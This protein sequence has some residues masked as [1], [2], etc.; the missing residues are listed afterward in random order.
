VRPRLVLTTLAAAVT[1]VLGGSALLAGPADA[2]LAI[3][4]VPS[5]TSLSVSTTSVTLGDESAALLSVSVS[6][7]LGFTPTGSVTIKS[8][9]PNGNRFLC[10]TSLTAGKGSCR[11]SDTALFPGTLQLFAVYSGD[12][13]HAAS[14]SGLVPLTVNPAVTEP[15]L[16]QSNFNL[17]FG[18]EQADTLTVTVGP[19]LSG[20]LPPSGAFN[21]TAFV[22]GVSTQI[23]SGTLSQGTGTCTLT[24]S[25]VPVG[26]FAIVAHYAGDDI[27]SRGDS[28]A[29]SIR[30]SQGQST[31][32]LALPSAKLAFDEQNG[33]MLSYSV[34]PAASVPPSGSVSVSATSAASG[35]TTPLC[36]GAL[37]NGAGSCAMTAAQLAPGHYLVTA[38]YGG[39]TNYTGSTST[40]QPFTITRVPT[41]T[42]L[43]RSPAKVR[44]GHEQL[45]HLSVQVTA[46]NGGTPGGNVTIK[47]GTVRLCVITLKD[48]K[49]S[50]ALTAKE[51]RVGTYHLAAH[52][53]GSALFAKSASG[54][55]KLVVTR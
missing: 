8:Q 52:Y 51:L 46:R 32:A 17:T 16:T 4:S 38:T 11:M 10:T 7:N 18:Q 42:F 24:D 28:L 41:Q 30:V 14:Q 33:A 3:G 43:S 15:T 39:D 50:C 40:A 13:S 20:E 44:F 45:E 26:I 48:G 29:Q 47:A 19:T 27:Y 31:A 5:F 53:R 9:E 12:A 2:A 36:S 54:T 23:C 1:A 25:A 37:A 6:D 49:G 21:V 35:Q 22:M 55:V 34:G